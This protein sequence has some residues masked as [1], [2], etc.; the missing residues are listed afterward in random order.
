MSNI[1]GLEMIPEPVKSQIPNLIND[2]NS[3]RIKPFAKPKSSFK[4]SI[5]IPLDKDSSKRKLKPA[6]HA[7]LK[8]MFTNADQLTT[9]KMGLVKKENCIAKCRNI[10]YICKKIFIH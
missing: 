2:T 9:A 1:D 5:L 6:D 10:T 8:I 7:M 4:R 3:R